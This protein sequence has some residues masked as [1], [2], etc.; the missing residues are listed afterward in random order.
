MTRSSTTAVKCGP[1]TAPPKSEAP[2]RD[3]WLEALTAAEG[4]D[5]DTNAL[6]VSELM[7]KWK[8]TRHSTETALKTLVEMNR[9]TELYIARR[10]P[11]GRR[12][13]A[14]AFKLL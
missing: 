5:D 1:S 3:E 2:S 12:Y 9:A 8:R 6:T 14:R 10:T 4:G 11:S 7:I 13:R